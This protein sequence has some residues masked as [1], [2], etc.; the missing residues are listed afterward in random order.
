MLRWVRNTSVPSFDNENKLIF[1]DGLIQ[2]ITEK[3][4]VEDRLA[5]INDCFLSF[6]TD[7]LLNINLLTSLC[8]ELMQADCAMYNCIED[9]R[10]CTLGQWN[11]PAG[12]NTQDNPQGHICYDVIKKNEDEILIVHNLMNSPYAKTDPNVTRYNLNTYIGYPVRLSGESVG[13]LCTVYKREFTPSLED[14]KIIGIISAAIG[15]E[16]ERRKVRESLEHKIKFEEI[17][18]SISTNFIKIEPENVSQEI[19]LA[20]GIIGRFVG[21]DRSYIFLINNNETKVSNVYEWCAEGIEPLIDQLQDISVDRLPWFAGKIRKLETIHIYRLEDFPKEAVAE[22]EFIKEQGVKS[23]VIVPMVYGKSPIG[24]IGFDSVRNEKIWSQES[25]SLLK[26][27]GEIFTNT[28]EHKKA[29]EA[30]RS[31]ERF[32]SNIFTSIQDGIS[33]LDKELNIISVNPIMEK[34]YAHYL[35][36]IGKKCFQVY[37]GRKEPCKICPSI[38]TIEKGGPAYEVVPKVG[39]GGEIVGWLDLY[40]FPLF[41]GVTGELKG[42]IEYVRDITDRRRAEKRLE[43]LNKEL[44]R[45]NQ[46]LK[47]LAL[48]DSQT[49]LYNHRY[50]G[51]VIEAEFY[52]ARRY[53]HPISVLMLDIDYFKSINDVYGHQFGD[54]ALKQL[55]KYIKKMVRRY[56]IIIRFGGEEFIVIFPG[57]D[58]ATTLVLAQRLLEFM[59]TCHFGNKEHGVKLKLSMAVVSYPDDKIIKGMDMVELAEQILDKVK[60]SGGNKVYSSIDTKKDKVLVTSGKKESGNAKFLQEK[61]EKLN[62][63]ANQSLIESVF[64][65]AKTIEVKD[66]YT[67][68]HVESTVH[69]ATEIASAINL[70]KYEIELIKQA[71]MLHDLGKIGISEKILLKSTKL[72]KKEFDEI[73]KHPQIG[74]DIIRP[75]QFF[76]NIIPL[77]LYHHERWDGKGYPRGLR[78]EEIPIGARIIAISDVYQALTSHR[79]Y[80]KKAFS[81]EEALKIIKDGAGTQFDPKIVPLFLNIV[82]KEK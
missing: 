77:I 80:R 9:G 60:E 71:S 42:A 51:E 57:T 41:D 65:F 36:F 54:L 67:G 30:I 33:I 58:R 78:G 74:V 16:E 47:Q 46:R 68:E 8:G 73:K 18:T 4:A 35:P 24:L 21:V 3:K 43:I 11:I 19:N 82:Q 69:Y 2:D 61:L 28:L 40:S 12:F 7:P 15:V 6:G 45:S 5:K 79:P 22:K 38:R 72:D 31:G 52:R 14:K 10:L 75:I 23:L 81:K 56:D 32:L 29:E 20:L 26:A 48:R 25:I 64:A 1:Y 17:I 59:N 66:H 44:I 55:A 63:Q 34:W 49:G 76:H 27:V 37:H 13:S 50:L 70:S 53:A 62:K 39:A